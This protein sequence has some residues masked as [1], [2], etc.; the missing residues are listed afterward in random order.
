MKSISPLLGKMGHDVFESMRS[1]GGVTSGC[2]QRIDTHISDSFKIEFLL[3]QLG[4]ACS[5]LLL[6][7]WP[8]WNPRSSVLLILS[9]HLS[10]HLQLCMII[11]QTRSVGRGRSFSLLMKPWI[12]N[13]VIVTSLLKHESKCLNQI[14]C[15]CKQSTQCWWFGW[16]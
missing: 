5:I 16:C 8:R 3:L 7:P 12:D 10:S 1:I 11:A 9:S 14:D 6:P 4:Q 13:F 2:N 15:F